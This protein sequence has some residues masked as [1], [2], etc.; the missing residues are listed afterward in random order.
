MTSPVG[1][2]TFGANY[3]PKQLPNSRGNTFLEIP[4]HGLIGSVLAGGWSSLPRP[5]LGTVG[6]SRHPGRNPKMLRMNALWVQLLS[7]VSGA[8]FDFRGQPIFF[9]GTCSLQPL[10]VGDLSDFF[11]M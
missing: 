3:R 10:E 11:V 4:N 8:D 6:M 9:R 2:L 5:L 7:H 1:Q